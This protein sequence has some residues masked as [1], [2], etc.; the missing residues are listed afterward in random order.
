M[1]QRH[2]GPARP[3]KRLGGGEQPE[4][5][6]GGLR[7]G[8]PGTTF[9][10]EGPV[11]RDLMPSNPRRPT[12]APLRRAPHP[13][14]AHLERRRT[15]RAR[16]DGQP[17]SAYRANQRAPGN[18]FG[19][20]GRTGAYLI[21]AQSAEPRRPPRAPLRRV[22]YPLRAHLER[23]RTARARGDGQPLSAYRASQR[24][25]GN[26]FGRY[27]RTGAYL[28]DDQSAEP[29]RPRKDDA[30]ADPAPL[31]SPPSG[32]CGRWEATGRPAPPVTHTSSLII[33]HDSYGRLYWYC[34]PV[35]HT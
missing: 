17:L 13:L 4:G 6:S 1:T 14:R 33:L 19:R 18:G 21:D 7:T 32:W 27:G 26:G 2:Q 9:A 28:I 15:A 24:A 10:T 23:R 16:G 35:D 29:R 30:P 22:P 11:W 8:L 12:V 31:F 25:P 3:Y 5:C 20:Y 34:I